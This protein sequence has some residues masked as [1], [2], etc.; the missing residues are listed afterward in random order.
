[1]RRV[2]SILRPG[3]WPARLIAYLFVVAVAVGAVWRVDVIARDQ[4]EQAKAFD[5]RICQIAKE[6][7]GV[8]LDLIG[9]TTPL[10][11]PPGADDALIAA[12][13]ESARRTA[14]F[15]AYAESRLGP[16]VSCPTP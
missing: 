6:N 4:Q 13:M 2:R 16:P 7:R 9:R 8:L 12:I 10:P 1:M 15:R 5:A 3:G 11:P 14:E